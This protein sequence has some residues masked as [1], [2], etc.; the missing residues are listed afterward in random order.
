MQG[1]TTLIVTTFFLRAFGYGSMDLVVFA[2][3]ICALAILIFCLFSVVISGLVIQ[4]RLHK[5]FKQVS[6]NCEKICF[7]A[8]YPNETGLTLASLNFLPLVQLDWKIVYPDHIETRLKIAPERMLLEEIIP[9]KRCKTEYVTREFKV[10]DVLG[11]CRYSWLQKQTV[12]FMVLPRI[13]TLK[14]IPLLRSL[15]SDDGIPSPNGD[16][17]GDRM[18]IRPYAPGD[19]IRNVMWKVYARNR[20]L[21]VRLPEKSVFQDTKT[22]AYLL[23]SKNDEAAAA[24]ARMALERGALGDDWIFGADGSE[25][26]CQELTSAIEALAKSRSIEPIYRYGL[27]DFLKNSSSHSGSHCIVFAAAERAPWLSLLR[28]TIRNFPNR[29]S[30]IL[31]TDGLSET[32][33]KKLWQNII[34]RYPVST[35]SNLRGSSS[36]EATLKLLTEL[37]Q[38][39]ESVII[40]DRKSG[41]S[42]DNQLRKV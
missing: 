25:K 9:D 20:Q 41:L 31:G 2:L 27:D 23:S 26:P 14:T 7:E 16:P 30:L 38:I 42:F 15:N 29:F 21:N 10:S 28:T 40:I 17:E 3:T 37:G 6:F 36:R 12:N 19:S 32:T 1:T 5:Y 18:E 39:V 11:F 34:F 4:R 33:K 35:T 13:N 22:M 8:E 24:I